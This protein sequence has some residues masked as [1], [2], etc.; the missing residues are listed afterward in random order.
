MIGLSVSDRQWYVSCKG[1][2]IMG[3]V[4]ITVF[5]VTKNGEFAPPFITQAFLDFLKGQRLN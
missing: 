1:E 3:N 4:K 5:F 2:V